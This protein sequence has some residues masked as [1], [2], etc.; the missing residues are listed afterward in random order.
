[1]SV[2]IVSLPADAHA[3][4]TKWALE[5]RGVA[6]H[7]IS[8]SDYPQLLGG[9][10][11][12]TTGA[13][14]AL[15]LCARDG[16]DLADVQVLWNHRTLKAVPPPEID[17]ADY[18]PIAQSSESFHRGL[19][20]QLEHKAFAV[21]P[22]AAKWKFDNKLNQLDLAQRC[23]FRV[24]A[25]LISNDYDEIAAFADRTGP[26]IVKPLRFM[27]WDAKETNIS[28]YTATLPD[29]KEIERL[30]VTA[31]PMIYQEKIDKL[32]EYRVVVFGQE[33][34]CFRLGS[35]EDSKAA[36][37]WR[38]ISYRTLPTTY[39][40]LPKEMAD[41]VLAF[42]KACGFVAGS[43]DLAM[44]PDGEYVFFEIN[45]TGQFIWLEE[46]CPEIPLLDIFASFLASGR[47]DYR[48]DWRADPVHYSDWVGDSQEVRRKDW[49]S[50]IVPVMD[51]RFPDTIA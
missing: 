14:S 5:Q 6:A 4:S 1:M 24:P 35:Q 10:F 15:R 39:D 37:D 30:A 18:P 7:L 16:T 33:I 44:T 36:L 48:Y 45:E 2:L 11:E 46:S 50:H 29:L 9:S 43:L 23:G 34:F 12:V 38:V 8:W 19:I 41:R 26:C 32:H 27:R 13:E 3:L 40:T 49:E 20:V 51:K 17:A 42:V 22:A 25:T 21:N 47:A 31:C 28:S